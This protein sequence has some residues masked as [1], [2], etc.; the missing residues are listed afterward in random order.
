M[1][2]AG[3]QLD[4]RSAA[5]GRGVMVLGAGGNVDDNGLGVATDVDPIDLA[6]PCSGKAVQRGTYRD[7]HGAGATDAR[8]RGGFGIRCERKAA[9]RVEELGDF[10]E[11]R[12]AIAFGL[13]QSGE[14]GE[15][16]FALC[17]ARS[18][19]DGMASLA[20]AGT[21]TTVDG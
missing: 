15:T 2:A 16:C 1:F 10:C 11:E 14:R 5:K 6:L 4:R 9:L 19:L 17:G 18:Q 8:A 20:Q 21:R 3:R 12:E 13:H 7:S